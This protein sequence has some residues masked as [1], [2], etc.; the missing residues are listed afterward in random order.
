MSTGETSWGSLTVDDLRTAIRIYLSLAYPA[1]EIPAP[2]QKR[3]SWPEETAIVDLLH[4]RPFE[5]IRPPSGDGPVVHALRLGNT[6]YPNM[7][8][9][10]QPWPGACG[11]LL[12]V[13]SHD[14]VMAQVINPEEAETFKCLQA[15]NQRIKE[16]IESAWDAEGLPTFLRFLRDYISANTALG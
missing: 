16:A 8:L 2:V 13:N 7:K 3:L 6:G 5:R 15:E 9:Q 12:S 14:Q 11:Y 10:I 1:A 4:Q